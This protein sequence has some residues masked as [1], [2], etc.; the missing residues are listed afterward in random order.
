M[1]KKKKTIT[2]TLGDKKSIELLNPRYAL[3]CQLI[4]NLHSKLNVQADMY[5]LLVP[6]LNK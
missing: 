5:L 2:S 4:I 3:L 6:Q 1:K